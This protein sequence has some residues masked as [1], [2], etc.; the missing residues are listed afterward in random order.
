M[1]LECPVVAAPFPSYLPNRARRE[2]LTRF[3]SVLALVSVA[4]TSSTANG[5]NRTILNLAQTRPCRCGLTDSSFLSKLHCIQRKYPLVFGLIKLQHTV[6]PLVKLSKHATL[7]LCTNT[8]EWDHLTLTL[9]S[10]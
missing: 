3:G 5:S 4:R 1:R 10:V 7:F 6:W 8:L 2:S 9:N